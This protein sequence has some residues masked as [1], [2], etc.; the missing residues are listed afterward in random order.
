MTSTPT[1]ATPRPADAASDAIV[2][3]AIVADAIVA[4][5]IVADAIVVG[6]GPGGEEVAGQLARAGWSVIGVEAGLVG[7]ECPYW[8]CV[9]SKMMLRAA[10]L[11]AEARRIPGMAGTV[12]VHPDWAPV[13]ARIRAEATDSWDD[14]VAADRFT[15]LGGVLVRGR[16]T[17]VAKDA[18][19]VDGRTYRATRALVVA[20]GSVPA[21]PPIPGLAGTPFWTNHDVIEATELPASIVV[22]GG[23][24]IG[25]ELSQV[26][27]RFGTSVTVVEAAPRLVGLEEPEA[28]DLLGDVLRRDGI[29]VVTGVGAAQVR[30]DGRFTVTLADGREVS[31]DRLLV[32][33]GRR[34]DLAAIGAGALGI[35]TSL[36]ALPVDERLRVTDGV[37]AVGDVTGQGAFTHVAMYQAGIVVA[38]LLGVEHWPASGHA[39]SRVTFTDPEIGSVGLTEHAAREAGIRVGVGTALVPETARGWMHKAGNEGFI[40]VVADLDRDVLVGATSMGPV[41]GEVLGLL[42]LAVH[43]RV[44]IAEL[45]SM[46]YAYPTFHRG[47]EDA[48][49]KIAA[50]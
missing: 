39:L 12:E 18:V 24:A 35:D 11:L 7:G 37:W 23:G 20:T 10:H 38:D 34:V 3:D 48:V 8:G 15:G 46:I 22:L 4:D 28:G 40:K 41:G 42:S 13:A 1:T 43:A 32:A 19:Q 31:G 9:P 27:A 14:Q 26:M 29:D 33:T 25:V 6:M 5:A 45:R 2:T 47:I 36:R 49:R 17:I 44:P 16:A 21:V 50:A 30:Y